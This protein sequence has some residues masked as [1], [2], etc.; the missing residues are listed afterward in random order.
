[1]FP[2]IKGPITVIHFTIRIFIEF[3]GAD[4]DGGSK[5]ACSIGRCSNASL[6]LDAANRGN[7]IRKVDKKNALRF[8]IVIRHSIQGY[9]DAAKV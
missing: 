5:C 8:C 7:D 1:M 3:I 4:V 9:I 6:N 2:G